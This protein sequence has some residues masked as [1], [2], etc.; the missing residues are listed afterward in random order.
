MTRHYL[1]PKQSQ[2][3]RRMQQDLS[4]R[5]DAPLDAPVNKA[6]RAPGQ[7]AV[8]RN[9]VAVRV[10]AGRSLC[11]YGSGCKYKGCIFRHPDRPDFDADLAPP[12]AAAQPTLSERLNAPL[13]KTAQVG[14]AI[15]LQV[16]TDL[17][18]ATV[19]VS[20]GRT[21]SGRPT[22]AHLRATS[23]HNELDQIQTLMSEH[24]VF[25][26]DQ[27]RKLY[28]D[29]FGE[30]FEPGVKLKDALAPAVEAG[31]LVF[32]WRGPRNAPPMYVVSAKGV[33]VPHNEFDQA[34]TPVSEQVCKDGRH[35]T[36]ETCP[37]RHDCKFG[38]AC[39]DEGCYLRHA[40]ERTCRNGSN[41]SEPA[42][43]FKHP[44]GRELENLETLVLEH[45]PVMQLPEHIIA[46]QDGGY[47]YFCTV[48][49]LKI[50]NGSHDIP[51]HVNG[52][53]HVKA[54]RQR[55]LSRE[56]SR[57]A[58]EERNCREG[59]RCIVRGC[60]FH[61]QNGHDFDSDSEPSSLTDLTVLSLMIYRRFCQNIK[62]FLVQTSE[63]FI[64]IDLV[65]SLLLV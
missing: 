12:P 39:Y 46:R 52:Q 22:S 38:A 37:K 45:Q 18:P 53:R 35:C 36:D 51:M 31:I 9:T 49:S 43:A 23:A 48:C 63:N 29:R 15:Q 61:H 13:G 47:K 19:L 62:K 14:K 56:G 6:K 11:V 1:Q 17:E 57:W 27:F 30:N 7:P 50:A 60:R 26:A 33:V 40:P 8:P 20:P 3:C 5:L 54:V 34:K 25:P 42:C 28:S 10:P 4:A 21:S 32:E 58:P 44:F 24:Q 59:S 64:W 41:C 55:A 16:K 65:L 2:Y